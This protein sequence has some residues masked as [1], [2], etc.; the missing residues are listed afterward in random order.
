MTDTNF[1]NSINNAREKLLDLSARNPL[2]STRLKYKSPAYISI[3]DEQPQQLYDLISDGKP[4]EFKALDGDFDDQ[5]DEFLE[6]EILGGKRAESEEKMAR[7]LAKEQGINPSYELPMSEEDTSNARHQDKKI[8]TLFTP[9]TLEKN[10]RKLKSKSDEWNNETG[11][12]V[13]KAAFGFV[14]WNDN[15]KDR[16][17]PLLLLPVTLSREKSGTGFK[18]KVSG[19]GEKL[20]INLVLEKKFNTDLGVK[21]PPL[22]ELQY[23]EI[24]SYSLE[25]YFN[26][27]S[28]SIA[29][30]DQGMKFHRRVVFG[31][32]PSHSMAMYYDIDPNKISNP[33]L[34]SIFGGHEGESADSP[35]EDNDFA[36][37]DHH[38]SDCFSPV[39]KTDPSQFA[40]IQDA[41]D[42]DNLAIEGPP[43]TGK[44][45]TIVNIIAAAMGQGKK[46]LFVAEKMAALEV[47]RNRLESIHLGEFALSLQAKRSGRA[48][49]IDSLRQR[50][51]LEITKTPSD[52]EHKLEKFEE[53]KNQLDNYCQVLEK[54]FED[55]GLTV[56]QILGNYI[57]S[58]D[59]FN[60]YDDIV[61]TSRDKELNSPSHSKIME[62]KEFCQSIEQLDIQTSQ[63]TPFWR[64]QSIEQY[65]KFSIDDICKLTKDI[66]NIYSALASIYAGL[67]NLGFDEVTVRKERNNI[68]R[69][70]GFLNHY[71]STID[72]DLLTKLSD[73]KNVDVLIK[74][75][76][77]C[78]AI[79]IASNHKSDILADIEY[80]IKTHDWGDINLNNLSD[81]KQITLNA[82]KD[83][84]KLR[85]FKLKNSDDAMSHIEDLIKKINSLLEIKKVWNDKIKF[86]SVVSVSGGVEEIKQ[87]QTS[88]E[89]K[90][91]FSFLSIRYFKAKK[92]YANISN[93]KE[94]EPNEAISEL[95]VAAS[96]LKKY[97]VC[98][99]KLQASFSKSSMVPNENTCKHLYG[100]RSY[101]QE[102]DEKI[103][104][105]STHQMRQFLMFG[106][107]ELLLQLPDIIA[108]HKSGIVPGG[109][110]LRSFIADFDS[111]MDKASVRLNKDA[112]VKDILRDRFQGVDTD[113]ASFEQ[114]LK[115]VKIIKSRLKEVSPVVNL[116]VPIIN[117]FYKSNSNE[118]IKTMKSLRDK[119]QAIEDV[120]NQIEAQ[121]I[122]CE[123]LIVGESYAEVSKYLQDASLDKK[124][125]I[126]NLEMSSKLIDLGKDGFGWI[127]EELMNKNK[128]LKGLGE[129]V[130][131]IGFYNILRQA[132][133]DDNIEKIISKYN[134]KDLV[135]L[136]G[137]LAR[138]DEEII[139]INCQGLRSKL[140][141]EAMDI[142]G[143]S[144]GKVR[145]LTERSLID[146]ELNKRRAYL[147]V[148][149]LVNNAAEYLQ[150]LK[151]CWMMSPLA[152]ANY[153]PHGKVDFDICI[154]DEASQMIPA[155][156]IGALSRVDQVIVVG[157]TNQLPPTSFFM[158][159]DDEVE[160]DDQEVTDQESILSVANSVFA[161]KKQLMWH[162]RSKHPSLINYS[163]YMMYSGRLKFSPSPINDQQVMGV[164]LKQISNPIYK[165]GC[166]EREADE[167]VKAVISFMKK[168]PDLS[169]GVVALNIK[170]KDLIERKFE[171]KIYSKTRIK[172]VEDYMENWQNK[173]DGLEAFF[174]KNLENVQ[175]D[176]RDVIFISTVY[177][178]DERGN[179]YQRFGPVAGAAGERR[180]NVLFSRAKRRIV[181]FTSME[182]A[183]INSDKSKNKGVDMLKNWLEYSITHKLPK[184]IQSIQG[185]PDSIFEEVVIDKIRGL[186]YE[187]VPQVGSS[188]YFIDIGIKH[189]DCGDDFILGIECDGAAYHSSKYAR[190]RDIARQ[191]ILENNGWDIHRIWSTDWFHNIDEEIVRLKSALENAQQ[192]HK[193]SHDILMTS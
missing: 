89:N 61:R 182:Y 190:E 180:L 87:A 21:L 45:D 29:D 27:F 188:G 67:N 159:S 85:P 24:G 133:E 116:L 93:A 53:I 178:P 138:L 33:I 139:K 81:A 57:A 143:N 115:I 40:V 177:G 174:I 38:I 179:F 172:A 121:G 163:N 7:E 125:L 42:G 157:D 112:V 103:T 9:D 19:T 49:V 22:D 92:T 122:A 146:H 117:N 154:I 167:V 17:A 97:T 26:V 50:D 4:M 58:I 70:M 55:S 184:D 74:F 170:Q 128:N 13:L 47:V 32:F 175:G 158:R 111:I 71:S 12:N 2:L 124:G 96:W 78:N 148:R 142:E 36:E 44:S 30:N 183:K 141:E 130:A 1:I 136:Q 147:P 171:H 64:G 43:G 108:I 185:E 164:S 62:L 31:V 166:N 156:A 80:L 94:F 20:D 113:I 119:Y 137:K 16:L 23:E 28:E 192:K 109:C 14:E 84:L 75:T 59:I 46:V 79:G 77:E 160:A 41:L 66:S 102:I 73:V 98:A 173:E 181:T 56:H 110:K 120:T 68:G 34:E 35:Y 193:K 135:E 129:L 54:I 63:G 123:K 153:L 107:T 11:V 37:L 106:D 176:E 52:Y 18:Y 118:I 131:A 114:E 105:M 72:K 186:G 8:Q 90:N 76:K 15:G 169:L 191:D 161:P 82:G 151:P 6:I 150:E 65:N 134:G 101:Y 25:D 95:K 5:E 152:I 140:V 189:P 104:G 69:I 10:L 126:D 88:I 99:D 127:A 60:K 83:L 144:R 86:S 100:L 39:K 165:A 91:I 145:E 187:A 51:E 3:I 149:L 155:H 48:E 162:Y 168:H 132:F